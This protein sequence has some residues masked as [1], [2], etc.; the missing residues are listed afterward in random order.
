MNLSSFTRTPSGEHA[1]DPWQI[2]MTISTHIHFCL[3]YLLST[4]CVLSLCLALVMQRWPRHNLCPW[5]GFHSVQQEKQTHQPTRTSAVG[6]VHPE[7]SQQVQEV[8]GGDSEWVC[9]EEACRGHS[10]TDSARQTKAS[11]VYREAIY[12]N[13]KCMNRELLIAALFG[14]ARNE[15]QTNWALIEI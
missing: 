3:C 7:K 12:Q 1:G 2:G 15:K 14:T 6:P 5:R 4:H 8:Q 13:L 10:K 9:G 11:R